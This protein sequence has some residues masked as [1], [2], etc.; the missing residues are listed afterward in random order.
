MLT[1]FFL[2]LSCS[3]F[4]EHENESTIPYINVDVKELTVSINDSI[5]LDVEV[6]DYDHM[7]NELKYEWNIAN[8][9]FKSVSKPDTTIVVPSNEI[10]NYLCILKVVDPSDQS[11]I[12]TII[13]TVLIDKPE[14]DITYEPKELVLGDS[15]TLSSNAVDR[16]GEIKTIEWKFDSSIY[17][18]SINLDTTFVLSKSPLL[19][20]LRVIDDDSNIVYDA[21]TIYGKNDD[22]PPVIEKIKHN[23]FIYNNWYS[24]KDLAII[25]C[26]D[27]VKLNP[28]ISADSLDILSYYWKINN[29]PWEKK[30]SIDTTFFF[31]KM[32]FEQLQVDT[33]FF[34]PVVECS[35]KIIDDDGDSS[36]AVLN[37]ELSKFKPYKISDLSYIDELM[38]Y[39]VDNDNDEDIIIVAKKWLQSRNLWFIN[40]NNNTFTEYESEFEGV[41]YKKIRNDLNGK[42][43]L[44]CVLNNMIVRCDISNGKTFLPVPLT[45]LNTLSDNSDYIDYHLKDIDNDNDL[46]V[47][48]IYCFEELEFTWD[49]SR[50]FQ[51]F[52]SGDTNFNEN[53]I[54]SSKFSSYCDL[55]LDDFDGDSDIDFLFVGYLRSELFLNSGKNSYQNDRSIH[56]EGKPNLRATAKII[57]FNY[58]G[59]KDFM[60]YPHTIISG[61]DYQVITI[62]EYGSPFVNGSYAFNV[63]DINKSNEWN[64]YTNSDTDGMFINS[65]DGLSWIRIK[66]TEFFQ[67]KAILRYGNNMDVIE[68]SDIDNDGNN[69]VV[70]VSEEGLYLFVTQF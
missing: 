61:L 58:D 42:V 51:C 21:V 62:H 6:W 2:V 12:D 36:M 28:I 70:T 23:G 22:T 35:L 29:N 34:F 43:E 57:D 47:I 16:L 48:K 19:C 59:V 46:D 15:I 63:N 9:G 32:T 11:C 4:N 14:V 44:Y 25:N 37:L 41:Q 13:I 53:E 60:V 68:M 52:N 26:G 1:F 31:N 8:T 38:I 39:D 20:S 56:Y 18:N 3:L 17:I 33:S 5:Y 49:S 30:V 24:N 69:D 27:S 10:D 50:V 54:S 67:R 66:G 45:K 7:D 64:I 65:H 55:V 40:N